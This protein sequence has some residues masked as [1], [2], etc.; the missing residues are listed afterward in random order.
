MKL[1]PFKAIKTE[2][3]FQAK[4]PVKI[5]SV[6]LPPSI[7]TTSRWGDKGLLIRHQDMADDLQVHPEWNRDLIQY[8]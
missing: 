2:I 4:S 1:V 7:L 5:C 3:I 6:E 8:S